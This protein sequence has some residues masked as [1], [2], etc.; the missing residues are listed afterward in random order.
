MSFFIWLLCPL[1]L[2]LELEGF[3]MLQKFSLKREHKK[4]RRTISERIKQTYKERF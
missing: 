4:L 3:E 2:E 1:L